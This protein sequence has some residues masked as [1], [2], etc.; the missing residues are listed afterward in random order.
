MRSILKQFYLG[1][2][3]TS[4]PNIEPNSKLSHAMNRLT[5]AEDKLRDM[6][7]DEGKK[8]LETYSNT[9]MEI[10]ALSC[11]DNFLYGYKLGTL[12]IMEVFN[13]MDDLIIDR[14]GDE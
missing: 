4:P 2:V 8:T 5:K 11:I 13:G 7:G 6:L 12:M 10:N 1:N 14:E 9:Q 3:V